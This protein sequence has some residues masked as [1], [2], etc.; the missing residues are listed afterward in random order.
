MHQ[1][2]GD[3]GQGG[4]GHDCWAHKKFLA[5]CSGGTGRKEQ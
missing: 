2:T 5:D 4:L 1:V 3:V